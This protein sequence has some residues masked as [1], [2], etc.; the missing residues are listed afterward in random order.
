MSPYHP[1]SCICCN[2]HRKFI[3]CEYIIQVEVGRGIQLQFGDFNID[4]KVDDC[5][6]GS[7]EIF[8]GTG[9]HRKNMGKIE[10]DLVKR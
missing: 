5:D 3:T 4:G 6:E 8:S 2:F 10:Y 9:K 7:V 1:C